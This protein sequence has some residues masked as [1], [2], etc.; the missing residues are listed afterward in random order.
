MSIKAR[1]QEIQLVYTLDLKGNE[2]LFNNTIGFKLILSNLL[3]NAI[4]YSHEHSKVIFS[5]VSDGK[6][7]VMKIK[8]H[9][10][11]MHE[12]QL[13]NLFQ[14]YGKFNQEKKRSRDWSLHGKEASGSF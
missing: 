4:K 14:K 13:Q 11:G 8:D 5:A 1:T 10:V 9:G 3:S 12:H 2:K 6:K 7:V